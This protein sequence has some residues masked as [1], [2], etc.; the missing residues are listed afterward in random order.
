MKDKD[1]TKKQLLD[2]VAQLRRRLSELEE[3][4]KQPQEEQIPDGIDLGI[5]EHAVASS[6]SGI[7]ITDMEG[8]LI[9]VNDTIAKMWGYE[10]KEE[11]LGRYLPELIFLFYYIAK[12]AYNALLTRLSAELF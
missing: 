9:Y 6:I 11:M 4:Q 1:K 12:F 7:G 5:L 8:K 3:V 10:D 2:E